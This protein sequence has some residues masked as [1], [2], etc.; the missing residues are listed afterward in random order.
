MCSTAAAA[1]AVCSTAVVAVG[2]AVRST[3]AVV[4]S[5]AAEAAEAAVRSTA[6]VAVAGRSVAGGKHEGT[7]CWIWP[8]VTANGSATRNGPCG[9]ALQH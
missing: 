9:W 5:T 1:V 6:A 2:A 8:R 3:A 4:R 7:A